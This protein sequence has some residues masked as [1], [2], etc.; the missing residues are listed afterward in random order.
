MRS[1]STATGTVELS[2]IEKLS[3]GGN[4]YAQWTMANRK[5]RFVCRA[6][7][8][9]VD[10]A[11]KTLKQGEEIRVYGEFSE[12]ESDPDLLTVLVNSFG[13]VDE[14]KQGATQKRKRENSYVT[15]EDKERMM[16][17]GIVWAKISKESYDWCQIKQTVI[18][19]TDRQVLI[20]NKEIVGIRG[21]WVQVLYFILSML[22]EELV[23]K[24]CK[25]NGVGVCENLHHWEGLRREM[26][27]LAI[28]DWNIG[29]RPQ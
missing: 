26:L 23:T 29:K 10:K 1:D 19:T 15:L 22:G 13:Y 5:K 27:G 17:N 6:F 14:K 21:M 18:V 3:H 12:S 28:A 11:L 2:P 9:N 25:E 7:R 16:R 24:L 4:R 20:P 8:E